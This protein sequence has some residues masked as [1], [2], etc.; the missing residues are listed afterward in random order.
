MKNEPQISTEEKPLCT[1]CSE[2][3]Q[4]LY[5]K[6][7]DSLFGAPGQWNLFKCPR[8]DCGLIWLN[9]APRAAE[10]HKVYAHYYTHDIGSE[11]LARKGVKLVYNGLSK[12]IQWP[13]GLAQ[14][15]KRMQYLYLDDKFSGRLLDIGCGDGIYMRFMAGKGWKVEG[16]D[17]D[18]QAVRRARNVY[19][20][21]VKQGTLEEARY[22]DHSFDAVTLRHVIEHLADPLKTLRECLRVLRPGGTLVVVTP[23]SESLGHGLTHEYW[24]GLEVPRHLN[25]FSLTALRRCARELGF[26]ETMQNSF[27]TATGADFI[28]DE[29]L[30]LQARSQAGNLQGVEKK[31][32]HFQRTLRAILLQYKEHLSLRRDPSIGE[33]AVLIL[34]KR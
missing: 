15:R 32:L 20:L 26:T 11:S 10:L 14:A 5:A 21:N 2:R 31:T 8:S 3:G 1:L 7:S 24:R 34:Q 17:F 25:I 33:E 9:P 28:L 13:I 4:L 30:A 23:N 19:R 6:L 27:T 16:L 29:S 12:L 22:P 18:E